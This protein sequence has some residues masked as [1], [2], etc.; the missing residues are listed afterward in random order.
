VRYLLDTHALIWA[1]MA[2]S[3]LG[4]EARAAITAEG[5]EVYASHVSLWEIAIKRRIGK[6]DEIDGSAM[7]W[8]ET[9]VP[10]SHLRQLSISPRHLGAVEFLPLLHGDPFDRLLVVQARLEGLSIVTRDNLVTQYDVNSVW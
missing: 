4:A 2:P 9:Y 7:E 1:V 5:A 8:F 3:R 6:I 10:K